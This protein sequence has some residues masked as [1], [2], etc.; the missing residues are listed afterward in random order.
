MNPPKAGTGFEK[1]TRRNERAGRVPGAS[2]GRQPG[3]D[4][5]DLCG[6]VHGPDR[7]LQEH[8]GILRYIFKDP[9]WKIQAFH[10][11]K[12]PSDPLL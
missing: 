7:E 12:E 11:R 4:D 10:R 1:E 6:A 3:R 5:P 2:A 8:P 9:G